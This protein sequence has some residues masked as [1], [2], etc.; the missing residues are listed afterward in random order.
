MNS[1]I[2]LLHQA[3]GAV[4]ASVRTGIDNPISGLT[5][6]FDFGPAFTNWWQK[7][8]ALLWGL[9]IIGCLAWTLVAFM[10]M[11]A[12]HDNPMQYQQGKKSLLVS[13]GATV[14]V[15]GFGAIVSL[16]FYAAN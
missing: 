13:G 6:S 11:R 2:T 5:A 3:H 7:L 8:F 15:I 1:T 16:I 9:V 14:A 10:S 4:L 12:S